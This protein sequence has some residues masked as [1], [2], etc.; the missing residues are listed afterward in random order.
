MSPGREDWNQPIWQTP[1]TGDAAELGQ[2]QC[3]LLS[4]SYLMESTTEI[5]LVSGSSSPSPATPRSPPTSRTQV[6]SQP[7]LQWPTFIHLLSVHSILSTTWWGRGDYHQLQVL[8]GLFSLL[9]CPDLPLHM[10]E[11]NQQLVYSFPIVVVTYDHLG[12]PCGSPSKESTYN[13][14]DLGL[15]PGLRRYSGEGKGYPLQYSGLQNSMDCI[16]HVATKSQ[17]WLSDFHF[18]TT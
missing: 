13:A 7:H 10:C 4:P 5:G 11:C 15:I 14:G 3:H 1:S 6:Q 8:L 9:A 17:T 16:V 18:M 12:F 2:W